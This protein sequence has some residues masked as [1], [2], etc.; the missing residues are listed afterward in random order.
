MAK[1]HKYIDLAK[2]MLKILNLQDKTVVTTTGVSWQGDVT[3][4]WFDI[5]KSQKRTKLESESNLGRQ[6]QRSHC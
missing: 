2:M 3:K 1:Q 5:P 4:I 6:H